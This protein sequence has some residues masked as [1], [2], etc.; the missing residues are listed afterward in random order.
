MYIRTNN[1][2]ASKP[3]PHL[4]EMARSHAKRQAKEDVRVRRG[5]SKVQ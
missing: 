2:I 4:L 3:A 1:Y 5:G